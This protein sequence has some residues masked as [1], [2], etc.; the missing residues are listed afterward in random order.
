[1]QFGADDVDLVP[2]PEADVGGH[3]IVAGAPGVELLAGDADAVGEPCLDVHVHVLEGLGPGEVT[4]LDGGLDLAEPGDDAVQLLGAQHAHFGQHAGVGQGAANV[5]A[6]EALVEIHRGGEAGHEGVGGLV[7]A[8][9]PGLV[10]V[11]ELG[12]GGISMACV[13]K[14]NCRLAENGAYYSGCPT[15]EANG[16]EDEIPRTPPAPPSPGTGSSSA[17]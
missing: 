2:Q 16:L 5:L 4:G 6:V 17:G 7:E 1:R 14:G 11:L 9:A 12:H 10:G 13:A 8:P 3:L 15:R